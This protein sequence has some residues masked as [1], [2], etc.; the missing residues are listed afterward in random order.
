LRYYLPNEVL[1][2]LSI[3]VDTTLPSRYEY[4]ERKDNTLE[5]KTETGKQLYITTINR[6]CFNY[7]E[8]I[9]TLK[10]LERA[11][12]DKEFQ[13]QLEFYKNDKR[14]KNVDELEDA[15]E[16]LSCNDHQKGESAVVKLD[17]DYV[18]LYLV[19]NGSCRVQVGIRGTD[20]KIIEDALKVEGIMT[21]CYLREKE[22]LAN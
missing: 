20:Y 2:S 14:D 15:L 9:Q 3:S 17:S 10:A 5:D 18:N 12:S 4:P 13:F 19:G 21:Q 6:K 1:N 16:R 22:I 11:F 8:G 7:K